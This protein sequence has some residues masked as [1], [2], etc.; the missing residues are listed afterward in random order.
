MA[1]TVSRLAAS[2][3]PTGLGAA[4]GDL[5]ARSRRDLVSRGGNRRQPRALRAARGGGAA[6]VVGSRT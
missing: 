5:S 1:Y 4:W 3:T 6:G 2:L